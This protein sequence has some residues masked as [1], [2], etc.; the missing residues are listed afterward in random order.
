MSAV[1][2]PPQG[3]ILTMA[4]RSSAKSKSSSRAEETLGARIARLR[5][6]RDL[7]QGEL[8]ERVGV[9]QRVMSHYEND[10]LRIPAETLLKIADVLKVS[11]Y[12]LHGRAS[13]ARPPKNPRLWKVIE[14][15]E[16]LPPGDLKAVLRYIDLMARDANGRG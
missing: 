14:K 9:V 4:E 10:E 1:D 13:S 12:E 16:A 7:S 3:E 8:G 15:I 5:R 6:E 11:V 2:I